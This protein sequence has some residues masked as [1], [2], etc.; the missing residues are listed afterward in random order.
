MVR[1]VKLRQMGAAVAAPLVVETAHGILPSP[2]DADVAE[3][4]AIAAEA[5]QRYR[6]APGRLAR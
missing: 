2:C 4:R 6:G 1:N 5:Q 3:G